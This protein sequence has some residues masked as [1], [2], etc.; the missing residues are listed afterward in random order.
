MDVRFCTSAVLWNGEPARS[1][2]NED[3]RLVN[4]D[5]RILCIDYQ[6]QGK[7]PRK[8]S[9]HLHECSGCGD[10]FHGARQCPKA[11]KDSSPY[12]AAR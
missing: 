1:T 11:Q 8:G 5:G 2:R 12:P 4:K 6:K 3:G 10:A 9:H 7:C